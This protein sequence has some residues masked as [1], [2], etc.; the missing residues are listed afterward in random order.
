MHG[1]F[2]KQASETNRERIVIHLVLR[3]EQRLKSLEVTT[4]V[5]KARQTQACS[6]STRVAPAW[7]LEEASRRVTSVQ[8]SP[9]RS[10]CRAPSF[11]I[12]PAHSWF[13]YLLPPVPLGDSGPLC[14][15]TMPTGAWYAAAS[16]WEHCNDTSPE[17]LGGHIIAE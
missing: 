5:R 2:W 17:R 11:R 15:L 8:V 4:P 6:R 12:K 9:I 16:R 13:C 3:Q 7:L 14:L 1:L 10:T